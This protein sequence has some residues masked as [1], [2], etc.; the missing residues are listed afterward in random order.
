MPNTVN[1][2]LEYSCSANSIVIV[3]PIDNQSNTSTDVILRSADQFIDGTYI[4]SNGRVV[5]VD[6]YL[7]QGTGGTTVEVDPSAK[8]AYAYL[9]EDTIYLTNNEA[10]EA[11]HELAHNFGLDDTYIDDWE[12]GILWSERGLMGAWGDHMNAE[13]AVELYD[14]YCGDTPPISIVGSP[15]ADGDGDS[16]EYRDGC[17]EFY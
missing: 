5:E 17:W 10:Y 14:L 11:A 12:T 4:S 7:K 9:A 15:G 8:E 6:V 13:E 16:P 1:P 3:R 2:N